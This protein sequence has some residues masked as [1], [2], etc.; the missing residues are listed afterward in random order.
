MSTVELDPS[1]GAALQRMGMV[2][3]LLRFS[4]EEAVGD[5]APLLH[6]EMRVLPAPGI[7]PARPYE[8][9]EDFLAYFTEARAQGVFVEPDAREIRVTAEGG[10]LVAGSVRVT[11]APGGTAEAPAWFL[12]TFRDGLIASLENYM[13]GDMAAQASSRS[14]TAPLA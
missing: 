6:P 14:A 2:I 4:A 9:R 13:D 11:G 1:F 3:D 12:Y 8:T 7:A 10:V 5:I